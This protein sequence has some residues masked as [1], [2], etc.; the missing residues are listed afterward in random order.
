MKKKTKIALWFDS[1]DLAKL[2]AISAKTGAAV[3][4]LIRRAVKASLKRSK[5]L[6]LVAVLMFVGTMHAQQVNFMKPAAFQTYSNVFVEADGS[7]YPGGVGR[8]SAHLECHP[9]LDCIEA[10]AQIVG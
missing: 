3:S 8:E 1:D 9:N 7:W 4:E 6:A 5:V 10:I 2:K